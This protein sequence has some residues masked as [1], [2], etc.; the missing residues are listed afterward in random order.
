MGKA[1]RLFNGGADQTLI[2]R[3]TPTTEQ[4]EFLQEQWNSLADHVKK[5][6][7]KH[8]Y[9]IST[10]L[11]GSYKYA[12]LIKPV[13]S[14]EEYDVDVGIYFEW[15]EEQD[16]EPAPRQLREWVQKELI[17]YAKLCTDIKKIETP[18]KE[19][20]SRA[21]YARQFH[22]DTPVYHFNKDSDSRRLACMSDKWELSDPK[23]LY[24][25]FKDAVNG[26]DR[27]QLRRLVRYLKTWA[28]VSFDDVPDSR[29]SSIFLTVITTEAYKSLW[30]QRLFGIEDDD[31]LIAI[32]K[33]LHTR[34]FNDRQVINPID[35]DENLNRMSSEAWDGF[36]PRLASLSNIAERAE[37]AEDEASAALIWSE[38]F[39][40]LMPLPETDQVE[41]VEE[42]SGRAVMPLPEIEIQV[43]AGNPS[44]LVMTHRNEVPSVSKGCSL[45]FKIVNPHV[46][47]EFATVEWTVRNEGQEADQKSD[48]GHRRVGMRLLD[49]E[50]H[51]A[52]YGRHFMDC[53]VRMNG[54]IY[55]VRRIPVNVRNLDQP[56]RN[57]PRPSY[58]KIRSFLRRRR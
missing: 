39:S 46:V 43:F 8:G 54:Q 20:C 56:A 6:L 50:E 25:W 2:S 24:K 32:V 5:T 13:H 26:D 52:Y 7:G 42:I 29:P 45:S 35:K 37:A 53:I 11:Q 4:R 12:T 34:L 31:A 18:A 44:R 51:T 27:D 28:A 58:T 15:G 22:I 14:D 16:I 19:R 3:V 36:L 17:E 38:A 40:F 1:T 10:W 33:I 9:T 23:R 47:P 30:G 48:L 55:A 57:P 21:S 41:I 49:A